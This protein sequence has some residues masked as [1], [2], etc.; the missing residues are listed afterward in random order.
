MAVPTI[1]SISPNQGHT[2]GRTL[3]EITGTNFLVPVPQS[4]GE[5]DRQPLITVEV[6]IDGE[7]ATSVQVVTATRA[8]AL[9]PAYR[10]DPVNLDATNGVTVDVVVRNVDQTT[11]VEVPG[12]SVT[13]AG[14][15]EYR[16]PM[17]TGEAENRSDLRR[18]IEE[19]IQLFRRQ[20]V[21]AVDMARGVD[22]D[23]ESNAELHVAELPGLPGIVLLG[24]DLEESREY[25]TNDPIEDDADDGSNEFVTRENPRTENVFFNVIGYSDNFGELINLMSATTGFFRK[26]RWIEVPIESDNPTGDRTRFE[27]DLVQS[28][29]RAPDGGN[30][31][32]HSFQGRMRITG[33]DVADGPGITTSKRG[34]APVADIIGTGIYAG[35]PG[36]ELDPT[37]A[38]EKTGLVVRA[39]LSHGQKGR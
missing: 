1:S 32:L 6:L 39:I 26:N 10:G 11:G 36:V 21:G 27:M 28:F 37:E 12:E 20:V 29:S 19:L 3:L 31:N 35:D 38:T 23:D 2:G 16:R 24:P 17:L 15:F 30:S 13:L 9:S 25:S 22:Y 8:L 33:F 5:T 34:V 4:S 18:L 14:G 7:P